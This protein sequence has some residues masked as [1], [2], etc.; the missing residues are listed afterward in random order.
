MLVEELARAVGERLFGELVQALVGDLDRVVG[1]ERRLGYLAE[2]LGYE[3][4]KLT[5]DSLFRY[6][7]RVRK[8]FEASTST[9]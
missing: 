9:R 4:P 7:D 2:S 1:V 8:A 6:P 5:Y 3:V